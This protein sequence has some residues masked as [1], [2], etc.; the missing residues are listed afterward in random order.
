VTQVHD[1]NAGIGSNGLFWTIQVP[2]EAVK[3]TDDTV[4]ISLKNV[5]IVDQLQF[6]FGEGASGI[7]ATVS[8]DITYQ[9]TPGTLRRVR[10]KSTDPLSPF[11]WAGKMWMATNSGTFSVA[12]KDGFSAHG[13]FSSAG[14]FGE[15]GTEKNGSFVRHQHEDGNDQDDGDD[16]NGDSQDKVVIAAPELPRPA[17]SPTNLAGGQ[18]TGGAA[19]SA[20]A[21]KFRGKVPVEYFIH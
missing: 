3:V 20:N 11:A 7:P 6:N 21:P 4:T 18:S 16:E 12:S 13:S 14:N 9:K 5:A 2:D 17:Q 15:I 8:F 1:F 19:Q 10:P